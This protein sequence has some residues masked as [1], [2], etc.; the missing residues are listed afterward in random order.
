M[1]KTI[2][3]LFNS[4]GFEIRRVGIADEPRN[5]NV[6]K[7]SVSYFDSCPDFSD[8]HNTIIDTVKGYTMTSKE[9]LYAL[10]NAVTYVE[11]AQIKGSIVECGVWKGGGMMA[12]AHTLLKKNGPTRHLYM[13][14]T[15]EGGMTQP[16]S[17]RDISIQG[18]NAQDALDSWEQNNTYPTEHEVRSNM[19]STGY[20]L[21]QV[22]FVAGDVRD[23]IR[24]TIPD[25][26]AVLRLDT[27]W[28]NTTKFELEMLF[29]L[30]TVGGVLIIDDYGHWQGAR[31][32][33]DEY[34]QENNVKMFLNR[35]DYTCRLGIK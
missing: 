5:I 35:V 19:A 29:P 11:E 9:R 6:K 34:F 7:S 32:A 24:T 17:S 23:T 3:G 4:F 33:V 28:Y 20:D 25:S 2:K 14:D 15:F 26:I 13:Y 1:K 21:K 8:F 27:D 30:L 31:K 12:V 22:H 10:I 18:L 16:D